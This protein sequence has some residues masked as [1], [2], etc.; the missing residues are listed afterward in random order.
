MGGNHTGRLGGASVTLTAP[1]STELEHDGIE[2]VDDVQ[3]TES[4]IAVERSVA[5]SPALT[6]VSEPLTP[7]LVLGVLSWI[8]IVVTA[9]LLAF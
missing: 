3:I 4:A 6:Q 9:S 7:F 2:I 5:P 1:I 8:A